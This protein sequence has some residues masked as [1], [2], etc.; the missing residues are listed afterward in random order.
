MD[1]EKTDKALTAVR[2]QILRSQ[3]CMSNLFHMISENLF[4]TPKVSVTKFGGQQEENFNRQA[5]DDNEETQILLEEQWPHLQIVYELLLRVII[6]KDFGSQTS[7]S[8]YINMNF[9]GYLLDLFRS[10]DPRERDYLK[11]VVHRVYSKFMQIRFAVRMSIVRELI[12]E[13]AKESVDAANQDRCFGIAEYLDILFSI[14][15]GFNTPLKPEHVQIY[16]QCLLPLHR[17]RNL[18]QFR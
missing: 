6:L 15:D 16:E 9:V 8:N 2:N 3:V 11:T 13:T 7:A 14:I 18:K 1:G 17:H 4:R 5:G 12:M 10:P